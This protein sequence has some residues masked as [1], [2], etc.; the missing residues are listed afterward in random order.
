M[1]RLRSAKRLR[2][3]FFA[4]TAST[5]A[6]VQTVTEMQT[7][8]S[9]PAQTLRKLFLRAR[10]LFMRPFTSSGEPHFWQEPKRNMILPSASTLLM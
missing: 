2:V 9:P 5:V 3:S 6:G 8:Y 1:A 10:R 4:R 7:T